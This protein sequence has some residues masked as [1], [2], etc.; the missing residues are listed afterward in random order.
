MGIPPKDYL[1]V[2]GREYVTVGLMEVYHTDNQ[3]ENFH[4]WFIG[5]TASIL[6]SGAVG[7]YTWDYERWLQ[8][9]QSAD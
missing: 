8:T 1:Q 6:P 4:E 2:D 7:I 3:I 9:A 5:Q